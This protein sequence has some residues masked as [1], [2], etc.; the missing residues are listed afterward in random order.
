MGPDG[1]TVLTLLVVWADIQRWVIEGGTVASVPLGST[2]RYRSPEVRYAEHGSGSASED[3]KLI[4]T[5][6]G[7]GKLIVNKNVFML[8]ILGVVVFNA[9]AENNGTFL[10]GYEGI[11]SGE[12]QVHAAFTNRGMLQL[13]GDESRPSKLTIAG[14]VT[15]TNEAGGMLR[16]TWT[17]AG[18][19]VIQ[20]DGELVNAGKISIAAGG[21]LKIQGRAD[22]AGRFV[23]R[24]VVSIAGS[25]M[26]SN[27]T[28]QLAPAGRMELTSVRWVIEGGTVA[29][30]RTDDIHEVS[31]TG[32]T[33]TLNTDLVIGSNAR[34]DIVRQGGRH[35]KM[36]VDAGAILRVYG[37]SRFDAAVENRRNR[38][39]WTGTG[40]IKGAP[41]FSV[42]AERSVTLD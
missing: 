20:L 39:H 24:G 30:E 5:V 26:D 32:G 2:Q 6:N 15:L 10:I 42:S 11:G 18:E 29:G 35:R 33:I 3:L 40:P 1:M 13:R 19:R 12:L 27:G 31:V 36:T 7:A 23:H 41:V 17:S 37:D 22:G 9:A 28:T 16:L 8:E 34:C 4:T 21:V 14:G 38:G 25:M